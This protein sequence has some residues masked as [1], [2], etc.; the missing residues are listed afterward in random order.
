MASYRESPFRRQALQENGSLRAWHYDL[1]ESRLDRSALRFEPRRQNQSFA[2]VLR[3]LIHGET[4][5]IR[6]QFKEH[7]SRFP[8]VN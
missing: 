7:A 2:K 4:R 3:I 6:G 8:E 5:T 1:R